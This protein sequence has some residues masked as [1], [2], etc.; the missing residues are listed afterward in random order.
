MC[1]LVEISNR[2]FRGLRLNGH[3]SEKEMKYFMYEYKKV[4]NLGKLHLLPKIHKRLYNL[5]GRK[6]VS[7]F[8]KHYLKPIMQESLSYI[9]DTG[10]FLRKVQNMGKI[11]Q[12]SLLVI[13][14]VI[15]LYPSIP[16]NA[17]LKALK[18]AL[19]CM[20]NLKL[21]ADM[22]VQ[23][24]EFVLTN[25]YFEFGQKVFHQISGTAIGTKFAPP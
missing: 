15:G 12:D 23:M 14:D 20:Q 21:P 17:G 6:K 18:V 1:D 16:H 19:D 2:F 5:P 25:N 9:K 13:A 11:P 4:T 24:P 3:I 10:D 7:Q 22:V 8:L